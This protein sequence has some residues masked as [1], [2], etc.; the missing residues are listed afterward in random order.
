MIVASLGLQAEAGLKREPDDFFYP[1]RIA[2][3]FKEHSLYNRRFHQRRRLK[4]LLRIH[5]KLVGDAK[6]STKGDFLKSLTT[7]QRR[8]FGGCRT[9]G[10]QCSGER[11][12]GRRSFRHWYALELLHAAL[13]ERPTSPLR[14]PD[15]RPRRPGDTGRKK[16][17]SCD[18]LESARRFAFSSIVFLAK[19]LSSCFLR[20]LVHVSLVPTFASRFLACLNHV[21]KYRSASRFR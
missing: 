10:R 5:R 17:A 3:R 12:R 2:Y 6:S 7:E 21:R 11:R 20:C 13:R 9:S 19:P 14:R 18:R 1:D 4:K 8:P 15:P 16:S